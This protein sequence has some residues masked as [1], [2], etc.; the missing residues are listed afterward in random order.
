MV[1]DTSAIIALLTGEPEAARLAAAIEADS[2]RLM[3]AVSVVETA[4]VLEARFGEQATR[5]LDLL[6]VKGGIRV[7][8]VDARQAQLARE[9]WQRFG[10]G[11]HAAALNFGDCFSHALA[12]ATG[13]PLL[14][15]GRDFLQTDVA[16]ARY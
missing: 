7:E 8:A 4:I 10:R 9:A 6:I 15:K 16:A 14:F 11:R 12:R 1:I 5:E 2:I 13:E 3:S